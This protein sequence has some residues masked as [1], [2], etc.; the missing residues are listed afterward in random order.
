MIFS[1][2]Q[3]FCLCLTLHSVLGENQPNDVRSLQPEA[4]W[5]DEYPSTKIRRFF[6]NLWNNFRY[7]RP[8]NRSSK[9]FKT[10]PHPNRP[11]VK[12]TKSP[13][14]SHKRPN[15]FIKVQANHDHLALQ[16]SPS[17]YQHHYVNN[18]DVN[19]HK[20][21]DSYAVLDV[22]KPKIAELVYNNHN[23]VQ[24]NNIGNVPQH[25]SHGTTNSQNIVPIT[26][27]RPVVE[28]EISHSISRP[29][30]MHHFNR[31][32]KPKLQEQDLLMTSTIN[33]NTYSLGRNSAEW[34]PVQSSENSIIPPVPTIQSSQNS[35]R[36]DPAPAPPKVMELQLMHKTQQPNY[37]APVLPTSASSQISSTAST[38]SNPS[39]AAP[40][41]KP[42]LASQQPQGPNK[43]FT[44]YRLPLDNQ[45]PLNHGQG[46][47]TIP[48]TF[49][50]MRPIQPISMPT[51]NHIEV[52]PY[53]P[54]STEMLYPVGPEVS[55]HKQLQS[56]IYQQS[57][58]VIKP[59]TNHHS[60]NKVV[61]PRRRKFKHT[62]KH[63]NNAYP[64]SIPS[65]KFLNPL[66]LLSKKMF[67]RS[68]KPS[69]FVKRNMNKIMRTIYP[70][71]HK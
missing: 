59:N 49:P 71:Y 45:P 28:P 3:L 11:G 6:G 5:Y 46:A 39:V 55:N 54:T 30:T 34:K 4:R 53:D 42:P 67:G 8:S 44:G 50:P 43:P 48:S 20:N 56:V 70:Y 31:L 66:K 16:N 29:N 51:T 69:P 24:N 47:V 58:P 40:S 13:Y 62:S 2:F 21:F 60:F 57:F 38:P 15:S 32:Q 7:R 18:I 36:T 10:R 52:R 41:F 37:V 19:Q 14:T 9:K 22:N 63:F 25:I 64:P 1:L 33:E 26:T 35:I 65:Q 27:F 23:T 61:R 68:M 17:N 12:S